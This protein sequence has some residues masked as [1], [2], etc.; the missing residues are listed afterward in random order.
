MSDDARFQRVKEIF[1]A[2]VE[3]PIGERARVVADAAAGDPVLVADVMALLDHHG[4]PSPYL[5]EPAG[6]ESDPK[7]DGLPLA[8]GRYVLERLLGEGA[9][10]RVFAATQ[11]NPRRP[12]AVKL[13]RPGLQAEGRGTER[14]LREAEVLAKLDH[15]GIARVYESGIAM[16]AWGPQA[17]IAME[18]IE[19]Q[20]LTQFALQRGLDLAA[21]LTLLAKVCDAVEYSHAHGVVHRDLKPSNVLVQEDGQPRVLDFGVA[22]AMHDETGTQLTLGSDLVGTLAYMCPEYAEGNDP[23]GVQGD[24]YSLGVM[25]Y[26]LVSGSRPIVTDG[27]RLWEAVRVIR[28]HRFPRLRQRVAECGEDLDLVVDTALR[29]DPRERYQSAGALAADLRRIV[30]NRPVSVRRPT[31]LYRLRGLLRRT[32]RRSIVGGVLIAAMF[33]GGALSLRQWLLTREKLTDMRLAA[34]YGSLLPK[35]RPG[36]H[37]PDVIAE[38]LSNLSQRATTELKRHPAV[39][40]DVQFR[41][42][43]EYTLSLGRFAEGERA[44][45][46]ALDLSDR[47]DVQNRFVWDVMLRWAALNAWRDSPH[48]SEAVLRRLLEV[49]ER[50]GDDPNR[51]FLVRRLLAWHLASAGRVEEMMGEIREIERLASVLGTRYLES[52]AID[53]PCI[54]AS[55]L[56]NAGKAEEAEKLMPPVADII[57]GLSTSPWQMGHR[58]AAHLASFVQLA[59]GRVEVAREVLAALLQATLAEFGHAS[60]EAV[61]VRTRLAGLMWLQGDL[62]EAERAFAEI[63]EWTGAGGLNDPV[64]RG[65]A[66]NSQGVCL[67]DLGRLTEAENVLNETLAIRITTGGP[68]SVVVANTRLNLA[69]VYLRLGRGPEALAAAEE[70]ARVHRLRGERPGPTEAEHLSVIGRAKG[71]IDGPAAALGDLQRAWRIRWENG[72]LAN[73]QTDS[74]VESLVD[75]LLA[76]DRSDEAQDIVHR[77]HIKLLETAGAENEAT[78][79]AAARRDRLVQRIAHRPR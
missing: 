79:R 1:L 13:L 27:L 41:I 58:N 24:V 76:L 64:L 55:A 29:A 14:F 33:V 50:R 38:Q 62:Q 5:R 21:K 23:G 31:P 45:Q 9:T 59:L 30:E 19:G 70:A 37:P 40:A 73:W 8:M 66:L 63:A 4:S 48:R 11:R 18:R 57:R 39:E 53:I 75:T 46:R 61:A 52:N 12:V 7:N 2:A 6:L 22:H 36:V 42:A 34:N 20:P 16:L 77:E 32:P 60:F 3:A 72:L 35:Y 17:F 74:A 25:I 71:L 78:K 49:Q 67:R 69:W 28:E 51:L 44:L 65:Q 54:K 56:L 43:I 26:E 47:G 68:E 10:G 15:P